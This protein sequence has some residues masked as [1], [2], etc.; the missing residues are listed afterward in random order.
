MEDFDEVCGAAG[1]GGVACAGFV[2]LGV[3]DGCDGPIEKKSEKGKSVS[4]VFHL[5]QVISAS[6]E[7]LTYDVNPVPQ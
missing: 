3:G 1:F 6:E 2:A 4:V 5:F 7:G